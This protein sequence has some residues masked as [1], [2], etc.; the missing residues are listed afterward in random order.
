MRITV[1]NGGRGVKNWRN[2]ADI[3]YHLWM[4]PYQFLSFYKTSNFVY[5]LHVITVQGNVFKVPISS[6]YIS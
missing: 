5:N 6:F 4:A 2:L 1:D 3:F